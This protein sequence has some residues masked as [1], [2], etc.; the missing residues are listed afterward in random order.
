MRRTWG[1]IQT[2]KN[3]HYP[4]YLGPDGHR[5]TPGR[6]YAARTDAE[7]WLAEERRLI[8]LDAWEPPAV[9]A[10]RAQ[11]DHTTLRQW[12]AHHRALL[13]NRAQPPK[14]STLQQYDRVLKNR[15]L[16]PYG[17]GDTDPR[18]TRLAEL[19][20]SEI[21]PQIVQAWWD[22]V[23]AAY[24]GMATTNRHA[25][26]R[27][28]AAL[29]AAV[30]RGLIASN[31]CQVREATRRVQAKEK[32][33]PTDG[34]LAAIIEALPDRHRALG[35]LT[36]HHG[37]RIGEAL[38]LEARDVHIGAAP[39]PYLPPVQVEVRQNLQRL[40]TEA[41]HYDMHLLPPKTRAGYR[42]VPI[43]QADAPIIIRQACRARRVVVPTP[44]GRVELD[45]LS[46]TSRGGAVHDTSFRSVLARAVDRAGA[47][48]RIHP[49]NGRNWLITRLAEQ[50]ATIREIGRLLGQDDVE[51][52][53]KIYM[54]IRPSRLVSMMD[55]V[56]QSL[57][58]E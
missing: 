37:L 41:G 6:S 12:L 23:Q 32:Y 49:H 16:A 58:V 15:V 34:E 18:V 9:R 39:V 8:E 3:R 2:K 25:Y 54:K 26:G 14:E 24:P 20:L 31:P 27:V 43:M 19:R 13:Q 10:A 48:P 38:A 29:A 56:G 46:T 51:T 28:K 30:D 4:S 35:V 57:S 7:L 21:T 33:L 44:G 50:G 11:L 5:Y 55:G 1:K 47:D 36:L 22:G 40:R 17:A 42:S 45:L 53:V 52:I